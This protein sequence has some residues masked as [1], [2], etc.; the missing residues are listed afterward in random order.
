MSRC[1]V[2]VD[3]AWEGI[4]V[5]SAGGGHTDINNFRSREWV[6]AL[7]AVGI[8]HRRI[9]DMRHLR[10]LEPRRRHEHLHPRPPHRHERADD[11]TPPTAA[12]RRTP[13]D[14]DRGLLDA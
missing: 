11:S 9:Y 4:V 1:L 10:H 8:E 13:A 12:S 7:K 3:S 6:P 2:T 14:Q 5:P